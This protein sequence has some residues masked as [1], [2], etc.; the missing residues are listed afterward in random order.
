[1][2]GIRV[3]RFPLDGEYWRIDAVEWTGDDKCPCSA[4]LFSF[5]V[6]FSQNDGSAASPQSVMLISRLKL[7]ANRG[8]LFE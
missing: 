5:E 7:D 3:F 2:L 8:Q 4:V 1:M 6:V